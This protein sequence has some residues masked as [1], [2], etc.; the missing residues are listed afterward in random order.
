[1]RHFFIYL[2]R[3]ERGVAPAS[4]T[5]PFRLEPD[6]GGGTVLLVED[7]IAVRRM[8]R[9]ALSGAGFRVFEAGNGSEAIELWGSSVAEVDLLVT[10]VVMPLMN[11][12]KLAD[13]LRRR[14]PD[15]KVLFMSGHSEEVISRQGVPEPEFLLLVKPFLP[16][17]LVTKVRETRPSMATQDRS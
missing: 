3:L 1:M 10:D 5:T 7:E 9:E 6:E 12:L 11:G 15:L 17:A 14:R 8:L 13:E 4:E 2:P 16:A